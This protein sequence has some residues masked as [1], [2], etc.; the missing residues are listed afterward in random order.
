MMPHPE[1][2]IDPTQHP[3]WTRLDDPGTEGQ[4]MA[5]FRNAVNYF[6]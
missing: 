6:A 5:I 4:G 2:Y 3:F 1:R